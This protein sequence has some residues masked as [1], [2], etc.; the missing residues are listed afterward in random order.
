[1][2]KSSVLFATKEMKIFNIITNLTDNRIHLSVQEKLERS[3][4]Q[5]ELWQDPKNDSKIPTK[6]ENKFRKTFEK[7]E[8]FGF[9]TSVT[10]LN[11]PN[12]GK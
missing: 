4:W 9:V 7:M 10:G 6:R 12:T 3:C 2:R 11:R 8:W 1:M 5:D